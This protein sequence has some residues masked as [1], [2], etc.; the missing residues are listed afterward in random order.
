MDFHVACALELF[1]D[2]VVHA[3]ACFDEAGGEDGHASAL[4]GVAGRAEEALG[5][6]ERDGVNATGEGAPAG[7]DGEVVG[8]GQPGDAVEKYDD[9]ASGFDEAL[10]AF[11]DHFGDAAV[12]FDGFVEGGAIY[13]ALYGAAHIGDFLGALADERDHYLYVGVVDGNAVGDVFEQGGLASLGGRHDESALSA[14]Y[15]GE[16]VYEPGGRVSGGGFQLDA[17]DGEDGGEFLEAGTVSGG[18]G[19]NVVDVFD[20]DESEVSL[21]VLRG[22]NL[23]PHL[24]A[25]S[26]SEAPYLGLGDVNV[27]RARVGA[28]LAEESVAVVDYG[29]DSAGPDGAFSFGHG[30][31]DS[32]D[33]VVAFVGSVYVRANV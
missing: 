6:V 28:V 30:P 17:L 13:L 16:Q 33:Q 9:I 32:V 26:E 4:F 23:A 31:G 10:G 19:A 24:V 21:S 7:G 22:A 3:A 27:A 20:A 25:G 11:E 2:N 29:E 5:R 18:L 1:V 14:P 8:A 12:V 15:G